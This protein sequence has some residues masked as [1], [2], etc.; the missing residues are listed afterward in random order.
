MTLDSTSLDLSLGGDD[1]GKTLFTT[2]KYFWNIH[3]IRNVSL[4]GGFSSLEKFC[5][6]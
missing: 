2:L 5:Y 6:F 3:A 1:T 4:V